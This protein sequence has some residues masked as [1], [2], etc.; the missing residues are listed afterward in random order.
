LANRFKGS[1]DPFR[2]VIVRDTWLPVGIRR[3]LLT[4]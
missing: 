3:A 1:R 2:I 4:P